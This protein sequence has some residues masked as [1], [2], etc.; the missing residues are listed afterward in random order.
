[1][2]TFYRGI[3]SEVYNGLHKIVYDD[4]DVETL[5]MSTE[6]WRCHCKENILSAQLSNVQQLQSNRQSNLK[7]LFQSIETNLS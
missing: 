1:M 5:N 3:L 6:F 2:N 4:G 7:Q